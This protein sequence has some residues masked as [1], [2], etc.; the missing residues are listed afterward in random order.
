[1]KRELMERILKELHEGNKLESILKACYQEE[2]PLS[3]DCFQE[4]VIEKLG[5]DQESYETGKP[6]QKLRAYTIALEEEFL[7]QRSKEVE[8]GEMIDEDLQ[9]LEKY[10]QEHEV[11]AMA[12]VQIGI[13]K[14][15]IY[16][17]NT[18]LE[19]V[20]EEGY[21]EH[22]VLINPVILKREGL[23]KYWEACASCL[24]Y[25]GLVARPY[26]IV[27]EY[28]TISGEKQKETFEGFESTVL[29]HEYDHLNGILHPDVA[30]E[31][32][33]M[34]KEERKA[35][36]EIHGYEILWKEGDYEKLL[37]QVKA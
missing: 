11:F 34:D 24:D 8:K 36:R 28:Q 20:E 35:F 33:W 10:C 12:A 6:S 29:S 27:V 16:L 5:I 30:L 3:F 32:K 2:I 22:R 1:M 37:E 7:R 13:P 19:N 23:T 9:K 26:R 25:T 18:T 4:K 21:D 15:I 14:R 17:K 31:L